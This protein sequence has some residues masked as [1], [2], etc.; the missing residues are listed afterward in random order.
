M[1]DE[2][3][4]FSITFPARSAVARSRWPDARRIDGRPGG[5]YH[6]VP[7]TGDAD[8]DK[9]AYRGRP[10]GL[11]PRVPMYVVSPWSRGGWVNSEVFDHTSIIR[12][13]EARFG[14][15]E[16][17]IAPWRRAVC[18]DLTTAFD[19][20]GS[21]TT[22]PSLPDPREQATRA[23][24]IKGQVSPQAPPP[25]RTCPRARHPSRPPL[26]YRLDVQRIVD[27]A[28]VRLRF[29]AERAGAVFHV[30]DRHALDRAPRRYVL[31]A[32]TQIEHVWPTAHD[33]WVLGPNGF[34]RHFAGG[35]GLADVQ[36]RVGD[37]GLT[38]TVPPG[39]DDLSILRLEPGKAPPRPARSVPVATAGR[40][41]PIWAGTM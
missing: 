2:N 25:R 13:L 33:L 21:D 39:L 1:F 28:G 5:A 12:F 19:F 23:A 4:G 34:H 17:N 8:V 7:S 37:E 22:T 29:S 10:Y 3:D 18:G 32:G 11:G 9:P 26:P 15:H 6:D 36:H 30:Y 14:F 16:P 20:A 40:S 35:D 38:L 41:T 24:A 31:A 27:P